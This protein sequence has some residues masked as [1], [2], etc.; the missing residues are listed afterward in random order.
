MT[1]HRGDPCIHCG[2]ARD[3]VPVGECKGALAKARELRDRQIIYGLRSRVF[4]T[5]GGD[6]NVLESPD[7]ACVEAGDRMQ[8]L[9]AALAANAAEI[10]RYR[11]AL[12]EIA[13]SELLWNGGV[14]KHTYDEIAGFAAQLKSMAAEALRA[15]AEGAHDE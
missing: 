10:E 13:T 12:E 4:E 9:V 5:Y 15:Q 1:H 2:L 6:G 3:A 11:A 7:E 8:E 14:R